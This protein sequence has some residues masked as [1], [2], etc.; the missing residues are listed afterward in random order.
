MFTGSN[1]CVTIVVPGLDITGMVY[2]QWGQSIEPC[3]TVTTPL[4]LRKCFQK[5]YKLF[6][7]DTSSSNFNYYKTHLS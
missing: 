6:E 4:Y 3:E 2:I 1:K 5:N 7:N